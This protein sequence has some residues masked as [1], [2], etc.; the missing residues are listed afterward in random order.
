MVRSSQGRGNHG[1]AERNMRQADRFGAGGEDQAVVRDPLAVIGFDLFG[2]TID[3]GGAD[4]GR[5]GRSYIN[6][7]I[8]I[9]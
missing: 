8:T 5:C 1:A 4:T 3:A 7:S 6:W 2:R 9:R